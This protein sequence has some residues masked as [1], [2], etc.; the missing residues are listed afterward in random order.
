[1]TAPPMK[2][3]YDD[4]YDDELTA[5]PYPLVKRMRQ[6]CTT[7]IQKEAVYEQRTVG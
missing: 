3:G 4:P 2:D 1:M 5:D 7:T 6:R